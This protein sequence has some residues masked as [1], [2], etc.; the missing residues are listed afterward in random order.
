MSVKIQSF[1][2]HL[3][4]HP[5]RFTIPRQFA[6]LI[7][8]AVLGLVPAFLVSC[9]PSEQT[10]PPPAN[11]KKEAAVEPDDPETFGYKCAWLAMK[12]DDSMAVVEALGLRNVRKCGWQKGIEAAYEGDVFVTP[13]IKGWVL[14][15]S[16]AFPGIPEKARPDRLSP[17]VKALGKKFAEVQ[18]FGTHRIVE[19]HGWLRATKGEIVRRYAFLGERGET[20]CDEGKRTIEETKLGLIFNESTFPNEQHV[21]ELAGAWSVDPTRLDEFKLGKSTG[22]LGAGMDP[23]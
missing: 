8:L 4:L 16:I 10:L 13:P 2:V 9:K 19:Y 5:G 3:V 21:M 14:A 20:L 11:P 15:V 23:R 18:Y 22:F 12:T 17:L 1:V 7:A 6:K